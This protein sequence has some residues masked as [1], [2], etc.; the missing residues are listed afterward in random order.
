M[1]TDGLD[2]ARS[3]PELWGD[4]ERHGVRALSAPRRAYAEDL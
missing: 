3:K 4:F 1:V 2:G